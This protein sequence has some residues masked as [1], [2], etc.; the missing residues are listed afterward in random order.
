M[1]SRSLSD[2]R[3]EINT[4]DRDEILALCLKLAKF[5]TSNKELLSYSLFYTGMEES[6]LA[7]IK[8]E[9]TLEFSEI[10]SR[11]PFLV[12]KSIRKIERSIKKYSKY[13][14]SKEMEIE[15][16]LHFCKTYTELGFQKLRDIALQ[17]IYLRQLARIEKVISLLHEDLQY[18]YTVELESIRR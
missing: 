11:T 1:K 5:S 4:L 18:D 17:N 9:I 3:K 8:E 16:R 6:F 14:A 13:S 12:K 7:E 10:T 15:I 2:I